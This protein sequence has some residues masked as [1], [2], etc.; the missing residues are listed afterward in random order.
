MVYRVGLALFMVTG[1]VLHFVDTLDTLGAKW[2]IYMTNQGIS[3]LTIHYIIYAGIVCGRK[4]SPAPAPI[5]PLPPLYT[6]S[7]GLQTCFTTVALWISLVYWIA[8][9]PY[10]VEYNIMKG[11]WKNILNVFLHGVN[12]RDWGPW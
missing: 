8:L 5:G 7:W 11:T 12:T 4:F 10:V 2:F 1:I 3:G 6:V 9:H